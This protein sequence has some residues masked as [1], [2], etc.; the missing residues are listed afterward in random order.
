MLKKPYL[1]N[2]IRHELNPLHRVYCKMRSKGFAKKPSMEIAKIYGKYFYKNFDELLLVRL[3]NIE[4]KF[5]YHLRVRCLNPLGKFSR[6]FKR[7]LL[8]FNR[9]PRH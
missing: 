1:T 4:P 2:R 3:E 8:H 5:R 6:G 7:N 9:R